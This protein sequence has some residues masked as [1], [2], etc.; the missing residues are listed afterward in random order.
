MEHVAPY[1][2]RVAELEIGQQTIL[3]PENFVS[4]LELVLALDHAPLQRFTKDTLLL[5]SYL[6]RVSGKIDETFILDIAED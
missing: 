3:L 4:L 5:G 6:K 2:R 1:R